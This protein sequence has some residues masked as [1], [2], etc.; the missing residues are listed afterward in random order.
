MRFAHQDHTEFRKY[1]GFITHEDGTITVLLYNMIHNNASGH[2][3]SMGA[4]RALESDDGKRNLIALIINDKG[5]L[6]NNPAPLSSYRRFHIN[7]ER[8][9]PA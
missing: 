3:V 6:V 7:H 1:Y 8:I 4:Y 9:I 5:Y 2:P